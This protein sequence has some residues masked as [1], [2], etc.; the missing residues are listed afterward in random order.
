[1]SMDKIVQS[2]RIRPTKG[3]QKF[4]RMERKSDGR[5]PVSSSAMSRKFYQA[6]FCGTVLHIL[7]ILCVAVVA[8]ATTASY[9]QQQTLSRYEASSIRISPFADLQLWQLSQEELDSVEQLTVKFKG[10][11]SDNLSPLEWLGIFAASEEEQKQYADK[12]ARQ[13]LAVTEA[14]LQFEA[15][16]VQAMQNLVAKSSPHTASR[17]QYILITSVPCLQKKCETDL[18]HAIEKVH[19]GHQLNV[20]IKNFTD[21]TEVSGWDGKNRFPSD[22]INSERVKIAAATG[23]YESLKNG[24][25]QIK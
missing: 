5:P 24:L 13:Q 8:A 17:I 21:G 9:A 14:I 1:M 16:Y 4:Y 18:S 11:V 7:Q 20:Y 22:S 6:K 3:P 10:V 25:Y 19:Q 12:L 23:R 2:T 15:Q